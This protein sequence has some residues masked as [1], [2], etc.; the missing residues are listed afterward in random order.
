MHQLSQAPMASPH[1]G[2]DRN[3]RKGPEQPTQVFQKTEDAQRA[4]GV[5][6]KRNLDQLAQIEIAEH[7]PLGMSA[8]LTKNILA[9]TST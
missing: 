4:S 3:H 2:H 7:F 6:L 1:E 9:A 8:Y 5:V